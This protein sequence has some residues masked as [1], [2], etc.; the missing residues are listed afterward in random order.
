MMHRPGVSANAPEL[1]P[2]ALELF[3]DGIATPNR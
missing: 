3:P 1:S 2:L